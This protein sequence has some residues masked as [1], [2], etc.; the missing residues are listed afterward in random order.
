MLT[1]VSILL[2]VCSSA[3]LI[4]FFLK[5]DQGPKEP[6]GALI[7]AAGFGLVAVALAA[8]AELLFL[9]NANKPD[10]TIVVLLFTSLGVGVIE[11]SFKAVPIALFI[12]SKSYFNEHTDGPIY[13][14]IVGL[15]FGFV[16]NLLY[17][18]VY[19]H[20]LGGNGMTGIIRLIVLF[21]F[22]AAATGIVGYYFAKA[23]IQHQ[24]V[25]RPI[26]ALAVLAL[27]HGI[28]DFLFLY[29]TYE[30]THNNFA[31]DSVNALIAVAL[32]SGLVISALLNAFLFLYYRRAQQWDAS[33]GL[34]IDP[35]LGPLSQQTPAV[36]QPSPTYPQNLPPVSPR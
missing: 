26:T 16:E 29:A 32:M 15:T 31:T 30:T 2:F 5:N 25:A 7:A 4:W 28:Y 21:F 1:L 8:W 22:H 35:S 33:I 19:D 9:P 17:L 12:R 10:A 20:K 18:L 27:I 23:K 34:A 13:F 24:G 11:E 36:P 3:F 6:T 14:G